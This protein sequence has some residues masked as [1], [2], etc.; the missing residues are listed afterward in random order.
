MMEIRCFLLSILFVLVHVCSGDT[1]SWQSLIWNMRKTVQDDQIPDAKLL[2]DRILKVSDFPFA[3]S[4]ASRQNTE[5]VDYD[6]LLTEVISQSY[7]EPCLS[8]AGLY[9][10]FL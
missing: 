7:I 4:N 9:H 3:S 6:T 8:Q 10:M 5:A 1:P 2:R